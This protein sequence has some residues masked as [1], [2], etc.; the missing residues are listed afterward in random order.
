MNA[1]PYSDEKF[2]KYIVEEFIP[3]KSQCFWDKR[4]ELMKQFDIVWT[5][6]LLIHDSDGK[7]HYRLVGYVPTDDLIAHLKFAKGKLF[8]NRH[9]YAEAIA[10][11]KDVIE[12]YPNAGV[13]PEA[14]FLLGVAEYF[15]THDAKA[16]RKVYDTLISKY[17]QSEWA[18]RAKSYSEIPLD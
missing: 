10:Q 16:L 13:T 9:R 17:P 11:F 6:T 4:T 18:R 2:Q 8:L 14:I 7:E 5:P 3:L 15:K 1:G 12:Q